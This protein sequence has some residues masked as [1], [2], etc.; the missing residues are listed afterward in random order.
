MIRGLELFSYEDRLRIVQPREEKAL[1]IPYCRFQYV[2][3]D[4]KQDEDL[5][6]GP[7]MRG[8]VAMVLS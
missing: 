8:Q 3:G 7:V 4:Y 6:T 5:L 1:K 2:R